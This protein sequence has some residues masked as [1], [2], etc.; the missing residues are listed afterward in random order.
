MTAFPPQRQWAQNIHADFMEY[1]D[2]DM[3]DL[4]PYYDDPQLSQWTLGPLSCLFSKSYTTFSTCCSVSLLAFFQS[5]LFC[6]LRRLA[7]SNASRRP[8]RRDDETKKFKNRKTI[9][10]ER[11]FLLKLI[12]INFAGLN[13]KTISSSKIIECFPFKAHVGMTFIH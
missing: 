13:Q 3:E 9:K 10:I 6:L 12:C 4:N 1:M 5:H 8:C 2:M 7:N 11:L